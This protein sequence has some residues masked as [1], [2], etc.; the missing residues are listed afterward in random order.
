MYPLFI[1]ISVL[2]MCNVHV[3]LSVF[4]WMFYVRYCMFPLTL[5]VHMCLS[6]S[7]IILSA[8]VQPTLLI[9]FLCTV[10]AYMFVYRDIPSEKIGRNFWPLWNGFFGIDYHYWTWGNAF[11]PF[12]APP[13]PWGVSGGVWGVQG[14]S[15]GPK[16]VTFLGATFGF[17]TGKFWILWT[18]NTLF[19]RFLASQGT[20]NGH[21]GLYRRSDTI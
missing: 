16:I 2:A 15:L 17:Q 18:E 5:S 1:C 3:I 19:S 14:G 11:W 20:K 13:D 9:L 7:M 8:S 12:L 10:C 21:F 6:F 4:L